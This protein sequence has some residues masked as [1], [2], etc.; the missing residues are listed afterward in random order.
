MFE[1]VLNHPWFYLIVMIFTFTHLALG[2]FS[3]IYFLGSL[4]LMQKS[5]E[6]KKTVL[7]K[8]FL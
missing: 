4:V 6:G 8:S 3:D 7:N 1:F 2:R 5:F